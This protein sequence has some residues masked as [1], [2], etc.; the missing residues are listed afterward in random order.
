[1]VFINVAPVSEQMIYNY[2][3]T[4][5]LIFALKYLS[6][7]QLF[8]SCQIALL[9]LGDLPCFSLGVR[10]AMCASD[11]QGVARWRTARHMNSLPLPDTQLKRI[12]SIFYNPE[13][14]PWFCECWSQLSCLFL[15]IL[16]KSHFFFSWEFWCRLFKVVSYWIKNY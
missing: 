4:D 9:F 3:L 15:P 11:V 14:C 16:G 13:N 10:L 2:A 8:C 6:V 5:N 12:I 7:R 1:M